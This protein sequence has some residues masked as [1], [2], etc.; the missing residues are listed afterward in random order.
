MVQAALI[1]VDGLADN[2]IID[3]FVLAPLMLKISLPEMH[4]ERLKKTLLQELKSTMTLTNS[5]IF[6]PI[7]AARMVF[8]TF[9][10]ARMIS[11]ANFPERVDPI[12]LDCRHLCKDFAVLFY[13]GKNH[14][15]S[16]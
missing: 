8:P 4:P 11:I 12:V 13:Y 5:F 3:E 1:Y 15:P 7:E 6:N 10:L 9:E 16:F 14:S 2:K